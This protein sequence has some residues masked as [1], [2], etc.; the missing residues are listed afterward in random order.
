MSR[1]I[2]QSRKV[3]LTDKLPSSCWER[4]VLALGG[5]VEEVNA[6]KQRVEGARRGSAEGW[7]RESYV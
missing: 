2:V 6:L 7:V 4:T 3:V 1:L 5:M